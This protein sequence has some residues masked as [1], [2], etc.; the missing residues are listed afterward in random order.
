MRPILSAA[1]SQ[2]Q[3]LLSAPDA[4]PLGR[5]AGVGTRN[6]LSVPSGLNRPTRLPAGSVNQRLPSPPATISVGSLEA[7][8]KYVMPPSDAMRPISPAAA[9]TNQGAPSGPIVIPSKFPSAGSA[10]SRM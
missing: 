2:N 9:S 3:M 5:L 1:D 10:R 8:P 6:S 4:M 7:G